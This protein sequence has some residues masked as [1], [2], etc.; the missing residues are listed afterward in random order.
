MLPNAPYTPSPPAL[1]Q[2]APLSRSK[3][4]GTRSFLLVPTAHGQPSLPTLPAH[5]KV[6]VKA[7]NGMALARGWEEGWEGPV[8]QNWFLQQP[9]PQPAKPPTQDP[10]LPRAP[11]GL[12][13]VQEA[14]GQPAA[15]GRMGWAEERLP[16]GCPS[17]EQLSVPSKWRPLAVL[18][19]HLHAPPNTQTQMLPPPNSWRPTWGVAPRS[20]GSA[21]PYPAGQGVKR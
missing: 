11:H 10:W 14:S 17:W 3:G 13:Y 5:P 12:L 19:S 1:P 18:C 7:M 2:E 4:R 15:T 9:S 20:P 21:P 8:R 6:P 16:L